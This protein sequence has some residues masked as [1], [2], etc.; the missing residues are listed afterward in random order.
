MESRW[1]MFTDQLKPG[2]H[3]QKSEKCIYIG[4]LNFTM[5]DDEEYYS[6]FH[7]WSDKGRKLLK[8]L[9]FINAETKEE[10]EIK[11]WN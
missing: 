1:K 4:I 9:P 2:E 5:F 6:C 8:W 7:F 11:Y 3:Y 10:S